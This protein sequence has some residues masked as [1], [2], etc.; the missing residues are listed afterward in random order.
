M[1]HYHNFKLMKTGQIIVELAQ[2]LLN[3]QESKRDFHAK[4]KSL[5]MLPS[6]QFRLETKDSELVMPATGYAHGQMASKLNIPKVYYDRMLKHSPQ[7]LSENVNH[8]LG[9]SDDTSLIRS[10]RG[11]MRAV[12]SDR[13]RIVD[14]NDILAMV[15]PELA[16]M[17]DGMKI[18]SCQVTES[19]M[20]IKVINTNLEAAISLNDPVHAGFILSNS[21]VGSGSMSVEPFIY[22]LVCTNGMILKDHRQRKN[23][24]GRVTENHNLYAIDTLAAIDNTFKLKLR[25]LVRNAISI[26][27][28]REAVEDLQVAKTAIIV[29]NPV[30]AV[31]VTA[32]AIGLNESESGLVLSNLI[33]SG[34]LSKFGM[35]NAVTRLAE[36]VESYDRATEIERLGSSVLYLPTSIWRDVATAS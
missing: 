13:Y 17:G 27:T 32:K 26:T 16:E 34:D 21:E 5:N 2:E 25:D 22:R 1:S 23:H 3:Q 12:L 19:K 29:G 14:H 31:E 10:L 11:E 8:W 20:Y 7:L 9:Q 6:G 36:D 33:R 30:K 24:V 35:L 15:L 4:T 18:A 28:F